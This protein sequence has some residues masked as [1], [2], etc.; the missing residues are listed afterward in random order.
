[1]SCRASR[2]S[3]S[4]E[5]TEGV[6]AGVTPVVVGSWVGGSGSVG[7]LVLTWVCEAGGW[8]GCRRGGGGWQRGIFGLFCLTWVRWVF[9]VLHLV[10]VRVC[11]G[12]FGCFVG[13]FGRHREGFSRR[14]CGVCG[15]RWRVCPS[16]TAGERGPGL[17]Y[18]EEHQEQ[19]RGVK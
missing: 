5:G 6:S 18:K 14:L 11:R 2:N 16:E 9:G 3:R 13:V 1:M 12:K 15:A 8:E 7:A 10:G 17:G 4:S 19:P